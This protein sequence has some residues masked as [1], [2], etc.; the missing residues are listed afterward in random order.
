MWIS[1]NLL[2][3]TLITNSYITDWIL[4]LRRDEKYGTDEKFKV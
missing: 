1:F 2:N 4:F 3:I